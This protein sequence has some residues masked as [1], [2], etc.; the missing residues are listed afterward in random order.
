VGAQST[1]AAMTFRFPVMV[2]GPGK[3]TAGMALAN[4][5][6]STTTVTVK[7]LDSSG[8]QMSGSP[9]TETLEADNQTIFTLDS[10]LNFSSFS[11]TPFMGSVAICATQPIGLVTVG[12]EGGAFFSTSVTNDPCP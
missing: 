8:N 9:F 3:F 12:F 6:K 2:G 1:P 4:P 7:V 11:S 5:N 10:K